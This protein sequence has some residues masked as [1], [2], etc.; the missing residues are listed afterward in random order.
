VHAWV[1]TPDRDLPELPPR[2]AFDTGG[3]P[4]VDPAPRDR[5]STTT[6]AL[7]YA[8]LTELDEE[9]QTRRLAFAEAA[10]GGDEAD[11]RSA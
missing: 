10:Q 2:R 4:V 6:D 11:R 7:V 3:I 8:A 1:Q 5:L 9:E